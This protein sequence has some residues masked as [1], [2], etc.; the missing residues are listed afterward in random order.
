M[1]SDQPVAEIEVMKMCMPLMAPAAGAISWHIAE[2]A[3]IKVRGIPVG[4]CGRFR[5]CP[6][7]IASRARSLV[8]ATPADTL[9]VLTP[10][11]SHL[12]AFVEPRSAISWP[13]SPWT[14][15]LP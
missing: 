2:G 13:T 8:S 3:A 5:P 7:S 6:T 12:R 15:L 9:L 4:E 11:P 10:S 1:D 14:T